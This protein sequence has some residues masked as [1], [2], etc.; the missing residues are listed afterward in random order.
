MTKALITKRDIEVARRVM[1]WMTDRELRIYRKIAAVFHA[2]FDAELTRRARKRGCVHAD[3]RSGPR[4]PLRYGS[5]ATLV[6]T[7]C[8]A[9]R[10]DRGTRKRWHPKNTLAAAL[11]EDDET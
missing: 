1:R 9:W 5:A 2:A 3:T 10:Q 6:C 4:I 8:G 11:Q 7:E